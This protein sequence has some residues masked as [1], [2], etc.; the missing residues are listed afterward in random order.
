MLLFKGDCP[1]ILYRIGFLLCILF[2]LLIL[3]LGLKKYVLHLLS[4]SYLRLLSKCFHYI[5]S[6]ILLRIIKYI[7]DIEHYT[8]LIKDLSKKFRCLLDNKNKYLCT[9]VKTKKIINQ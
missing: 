6:R 4:C 7:K 2:W 3:I 8:G 9:K 5:Y 1:E